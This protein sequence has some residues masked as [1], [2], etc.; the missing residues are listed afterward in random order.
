MKNIC[1]F[2]EQKKELVESHIVPK[3]IFDWL[4]K[5]SATNSLRATPAVNESQGVIL[6]F[7]REEYKLQFS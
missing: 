4:K 3:F 7:K 1:R 5:T 6:K 2:R